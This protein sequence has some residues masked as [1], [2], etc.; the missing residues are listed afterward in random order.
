MLVGET[1]FDLGM[2]FPFCLHLVPIHLPM[3]INELLAALLFED[4]S[5][6]V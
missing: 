4:Y 2:L 1:Y 5:F 6:V 3:L